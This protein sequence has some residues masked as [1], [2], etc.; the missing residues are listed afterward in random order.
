MCFWRTSARRAK[1]Y[2]GFFRVSEAG[3]A[4]DALGYVTWRRRSAILLWIGQRDGGDAWRTLQGD[5]RARG[6]DLRRANTAPL[7][8]TEY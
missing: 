2:L 3:A 4:K 5:V 8:R 1:W 6:H 7:R